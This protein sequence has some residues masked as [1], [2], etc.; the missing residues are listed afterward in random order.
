MDK[1]EKPRGPRESEQEHRDTSLGVRPSLHPARSPRQR[2]PHF[3]ALLVTGG[4]LLCRRIECFH[5]YD[6]RSRHIKVLRYVTAPE[7]AGRRCAS[8]GEG[9]APKPGFLR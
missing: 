6:G 3:A 9:L 7:A 5:A 1:A 4:R 8:C 2:E